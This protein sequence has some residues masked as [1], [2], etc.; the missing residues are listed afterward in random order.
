MLGS[1]FSLGFNSPFSPGVDRWT[2]GYE[3]QIT[4]LD[5]I[6]IEFGIEAR[7]TYHYFGG[8]HSG[9]SVIAMLYQFLS[10]PFHTDADGLY[11]YDEWRI[12]PN[13][14]VRW[15]LGPWAYQS[16]DWT[17]YVDGYVTLRVPVVAASGSPQGVVPQSTGPVPV[18]LSTRHQQQWRRQQP[19]SDLAISSESNPQ[20][21]F[22]T[23]YNEIPPDTSRLYRP[24]GMTKYV[25][26]MVKLTEMMGSAERPAGLTAAQ[27]EPIAADQF[28]RLAQY[29]DRSSTTSDY[30]RAA[31]LVELLTHLGKDTEEV[32]A[33]NG[34][35]R[36][37]RV[38]IV[39]RKDDEG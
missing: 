37:R 9:E 39:V 20:L 1:N 13:R 23:A 10:R 35:L 7:V 2:S 25:K 16:R 5:S 36:D 19:G 6:P 8:S 38:G 31:L 15:N 34:I 24:L 3:L 18:L 28:P 14:A 26:E 11:C 32:A 12:E 21:A 30:E 17:P 4:N 29:Q 22:G 33:L 27:R